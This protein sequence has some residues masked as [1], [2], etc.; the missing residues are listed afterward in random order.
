MENQKH[1]AESRRQWRKVHLGIDAQTLQ[2]RAIAVTTNEVGDSPM[3]A[4]LQVKFKQ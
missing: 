1:G 4:D 2:I 3:A